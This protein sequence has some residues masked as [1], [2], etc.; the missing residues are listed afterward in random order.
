M[1][2][3]TRGTNDSLKF[4]GNRFRFQI[5]TA[6]KPQF[7]FK[8][9]SW[10]QL[11]LPIN[12]YNERLFVTGSSTKYEQYVGFHIVGPLHFLFCFWIEFGFV[13]TFLGYNHRYIFLRNNSTTELCQN[14]I[15]L[16][17]SKKFQETKKAEKTCV[18]RLR[19]SHR[20]VNKVEFII[21]PNFNI[22]YLNRLDF[23]KFLYF[24][25]VE[26]TTMLPMA[27]T[28]LCWLQI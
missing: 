27:M 26:S 3:G 12:Y 20:K 1:L 4:G 6:P 19:A 21:F 13:Y 25:Y 15:F 7:A 24:Q 9:G 16:N 5:V 8:N 22:I 18:Q 11:V 23:L 17:N 2:F 10:V 28:G 14:S